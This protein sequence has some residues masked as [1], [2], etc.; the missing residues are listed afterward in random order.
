MTSRSPLLASWVELLGPAEDVVLA[1]QQL[2]ERYAEPSRRYHDLRHLAEVLD[3]LRLLAGAE[4][5]APVLL[6]AYWHDA[7]YSG[8]AGDDEERS[9]ELADLVLTGL[10]RSPEEVGEVVRLVLLTR[11]HDPEQAD[12]AGALLCD[13]DLAVLASPPDRYRSYVTGVRQEYA[14]LSDEAFRAGRAGVLRVLDRHEHLF[15]T[16][17]GRRR[18]EARARQNLRSELD[19]LGAVPPL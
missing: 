2:L 7:V 1:G 5:P 3:A 16:P 15:R 4:V 11:T 19:E 17:E 9:A 12:A 14:H 10:G 13:A 6:A 8:R 18:W